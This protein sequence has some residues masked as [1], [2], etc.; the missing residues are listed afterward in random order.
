M[1]IYMKAHGKMDLS[2]GKEI[3][4]GV[5]EIVIKVIFGKIKDKEKQ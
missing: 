1:E 5:M 3:I 4:N 2:M